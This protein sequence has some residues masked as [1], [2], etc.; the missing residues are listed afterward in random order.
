[1]SRKLAG[2]TNTETTEE[3][4]TQ[5]AQQAQPQPVGLGRGVRF[6]FRVFGGDSQAFRGDS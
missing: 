5:H 6:R 3:D 1:M 4:T 2:R